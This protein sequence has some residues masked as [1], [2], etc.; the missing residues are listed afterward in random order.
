MKLQTRLYVTRQGC[1]DAAA[2]RTLAYELAPPLDELYGKATI[3]GYQALVLK[4]EDDYAEY[5]LDQS[6]IERE[7][8]GS[9]PAI[10]LN[11]TYRIDL[12]PPDTSVIDRLVENYGFRHMLTESDAPSSPAGAKR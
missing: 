7:T 9:L 10:F 6:M 12:S 5:D 4:S 11:V 1:T 8:Q 3:A 2:A